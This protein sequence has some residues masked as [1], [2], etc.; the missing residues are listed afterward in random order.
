MDG[1]STDSGCNTHRHVSGD[2]DPDLLSELERGGHGGLR[3]SSHGESCAC[4][5]GFSMANG[6]S[7]QVS[8]Q[9]RGT[10]QVPSI[11]GGGSAGSRSIIPTGNNFDDTTPCSCWM[12]L[13]Q[14]VICPKG[15]RG[16]Q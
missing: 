13:A 7:A 8:V 11:I 4:G 2:P 10:Y 9:S 14:K 5:S 1:D 3:A 6:A 15:K 16:D 12:V